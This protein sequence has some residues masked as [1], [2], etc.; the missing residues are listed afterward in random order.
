MVCLERDSLLTRYIHR[1]FEFVPNIVQI[2]VSSEWTEKHVVLPG[3]WTAVA[4]SYTKDTT[5]QD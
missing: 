4:F 2:S 3:Q 1:T 5:E